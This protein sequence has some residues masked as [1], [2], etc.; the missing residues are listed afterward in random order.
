MQNKFIPGQ[1]WISETEPE[2]GLGSVLA[3]EGQEIRIQFPSSDIIRQYTAD[4]APLKRI[5][6]HTGDQIS[7][8][9]G[10]TL[11]V[12]SVVEKDGLIVYHGL[13]GVIEESQL[14]DSLDFS[15]P[16]DR[17]IL[18]QPDPNHLFELRFTAL[19]KRRWLETSK[20]RGLLGA[21]ISLLPHQLYIASEV[22]SRHQIRVLLG[23]EVG[24]GKTIEA[25]LILHRQVQTGRCS[26]VLILLPESLTHQWFLELWRRFNLIFSL[27]D[28]ERCASIEAIN[29]GQNPFSESAFVLCSLDFLEANPNRS[30]QVCAGDWD[31]LLVDEAH[32]LTW[33]ENNPSLGY[34]IVKELAEKISSVIL[35]SGTPEQLGEDGHFA[36]LHLL[37]PHRFH[38]LKKFRKEQEEFSA[39]AKIVNKLLENKTLRGNDLKTLCETYRY[40]P[41]KLKIQLERIKCGDSKQKNKLIAELVDR[42]GTG[43][44]FYRVQRNHIGG[45]PIRSPIFYALE[46]SKPC[47][48]LFREGQSPEIISPPEFEIPEEDWEKW[49]LNDP[50]IDTVIKILNDHPHDKFLL[51]CTKKETVLA[52]QEAIERKIKIPLGLFHENLSL[53]VRDR[54]AAYFAKPDGAR[55]LLCSEIGSE[56]RNFQFCHHLILFDLPKN[57]EVLEQRIGR[58][59]R[60]GQKHEIT[61]HIIYLKNTSQEVLGLWYD[62]GLNAFRHPVRGAN[63]LY[64]KFKEPVL[65]LG[66]ERFDNPSSKKLQQLVQST[67]KTMKEAI[68]KLE[69]GRDR[70]LEW[71]SH[72]PEKGSLLVEEIENVESL[73][74][75]PSF[76]E[77]LCQHLGV[78]VEDHDYNSLYFIPGDLYQGLPGLK[79]EGLSV[80]FSRQRALTREDM[81]FLSWEHP[82]VVGGMDQLLGSASGKASYGHWEDPESRSVLLEVLFIVYCLAPRKLHPE[83]F[84][85]QTPLR[86]LVN[87]SGKDLSGEISDTELR[88]VLRDDPQAAF[89]QKPE[90]KQQLIPSMVKRSQELAERKKE[91]ILAQALASIQATLNPEITRLKDL[92]SDQAPVRSEEITQLQEEIQDL[93]QFIAEA[94]LRIDSIRFIWRGA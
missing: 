86:I 46:M 67:Q 71:H 63:K 87:H 26:R 41:E 62:Q 25:G 70:L 8:S 53:V 57:P 78:Q 10:K 61:I 23:D 28:E 92:R 17:L 75:L 77:N 66:R 30:K 60:I 79:E 27:Y 39:V 38:D 21:R 37:D 68:H 50:R 93:S 90:V 89:L 91:E 36:R 76:M 83:R 15:S 72:Q 40:D 44:L 5:R 94:S 19:K 69:T 22:G 16:V 74:N 14:C 49:W 80:T 35:I 7:S 65:H 3:S 64:Q 32:H 1:R 33:N 52:I 12:N 47:E 11:T 42:H 58:L 51:I 9:D 73:S 43:R 6:F 13:E 24:L 85:P 56:G 4:G 59:D 82:M 29:P 48:D 54:N 31:M 84:L 88:K 55:L 45:F 20:V 34:R 81:T 18:G 2:L